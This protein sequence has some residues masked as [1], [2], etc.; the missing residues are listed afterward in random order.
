[1]PEREAELQLI[2]VTTEA[3]KDH[4]NTKQT[5]WPTSTEPSTAGA[6]PAKKGS[7]K[8]YIFFLSKE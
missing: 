1:M 2:L 4:L 5:E 8:L 7:L 3:L 6:I